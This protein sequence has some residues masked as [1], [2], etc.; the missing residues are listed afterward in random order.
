MFAAEIGATT[1]PLAQLNKD[2]NEERPPV[3]DP[4]CT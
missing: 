2:R 3:D 4:D 1:V